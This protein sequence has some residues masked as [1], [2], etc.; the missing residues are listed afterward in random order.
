[1]ITSQQMPTAQAIEDAKR[2]WMQAEM[3]DTWDKPAD[4]PDYIAKCEAYERY[5]ALSIMPAPKTPETPLLMAGGGTPEAGRVSGVIGY[6]CR[7]YGYISVEGED[8]VKFL[9]RH[10]FGRVPMKGDKVT[11][12]RGLTGGA[13]D[14]VL[15]GA[16]TSREAYSAKI[17]QRP[18]LPRV[19]RGR[20]NF[21]EGFQF[22][23]SKDE[24]QAARERVAKLREGLS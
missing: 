5:M 21:G 10:V 18:S 19:R 6:I 14:V 12:T 11:F 15:E 2:A 16:V 22:T 4:H 3:I 13:I 9:P 20:A 24:L 1:M 23:E 17:A 8:D 7:D